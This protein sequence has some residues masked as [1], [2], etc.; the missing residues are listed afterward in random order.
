[1][2]Q[3]AALARYEAQQLAGMDPQRC[4]VCAQPAGMKQPETAEMAG[5][6]PDR[7]Q[8]ERDQ[9]ERDQLERDEMAAWVCAQERAGGEVVVVTDVEA[10]SQPYAHHEVRRL[11]ARCLGANQALWLYL[12]SP[13]PTFGGESYLAV[14]R[15]AWRISAFQR[16]SITVRWAGALLTMDTRAPGVDRPQA[17][18][19]FV[20]EARRHALAHADQSRRGSEDADWELESSGNG[21][22]DNRVRVFFTSGCVGCGRE[23]DSLT[24][25]NMAT[26]SISLSGSPLQRRPSLRQPADKTLTYTHGPRG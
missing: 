11:C 24:A 9:L 12:Q 20:A 22:V 8:P 2:L 16:T 6:P 19:R 10:A 18:A 3:M 7:D 15:R 13:L 23:Q 1:M 21:D 5:R 26:F 17:I 25:I 14:A 4:V